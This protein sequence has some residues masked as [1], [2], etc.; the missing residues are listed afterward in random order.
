[1]EKDLPKANIKEII[2]LPKQLNA[3]TTL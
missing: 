2:W 3:M 1:L